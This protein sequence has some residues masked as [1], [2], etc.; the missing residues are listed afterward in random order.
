[1]IISSQGFGHFVQ[2]LNNQDFGIETP[3]MLLVLDGCSGAKYSEVG[4]RLFA[5]I[6][7]RKEECDNHEK[8]EDN[9]KEVFEEI[10]GMMKKYYP[11]KDDLEKEFIM[12]NLLFTIIACF[13]TEDKY[14]VKIFGDGYIITQN[15][16]GCVSYM[17]FYYG[18]FPPYFAYKYCS[19][20]NF[21]AHQFKTFE[22][23][24]KDFPKVGIGSDGVVP[25]AK[26][27]LKGIDNIIFG[28]NKDKLELAI[29]NR[30]QSFSDDVTIGAFEGGKD[31][32]TVQRFLW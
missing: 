12:E 5:Q 4:T 31:S 27:E 22:F 24:K 25:M 32:E 23:D 28:G 19:D 18:K 30:R 1:M 6:F 7:T 29:K 10:I 21:Q 16:Q 9:V 15:K 20:M 8:F 17:K 14:I 3:R 11:T 2:G 13:E 26:G